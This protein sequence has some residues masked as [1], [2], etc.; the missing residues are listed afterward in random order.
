MQKSSY[1]PSPFRKDYTSKPLRN[2]NPVIIK[3]PSKPVTIVEQPQKEKTIKYSDGLLV[4]IAD[5]GTRESGF[6]FTRNYS[7]MIFNLE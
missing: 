3:E 2:F 1:F 6:F 7:C 4:N 5:K